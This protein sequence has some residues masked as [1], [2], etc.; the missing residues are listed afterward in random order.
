LE[1]PFSRFSIEQIRRVV[2]EKGVVEAINVTTLWEWLHEDG[3]R[4]WTHRP[5]IF[6]RDPDSLRRG[7]LVLDRYHRIWDGKPLTENDFVIRPTKRPAFKRAD[8]NIRVRRLPPSGQVGAR[9]GAQGSAGV[10]GRVRHPSSERI[11]AM[12]RHHRHHSVWQIG[13]QRD[14]TGTVPVRSSGVLDRR[15]RIVTS[16][17][18]GG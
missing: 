13:R 3:L 1:L 4:P 14:G 5:W 11:R 2:I 16:R 18:G 6:P 7:S 9:I 10:P 17:T 15:Q 8:E 12:R